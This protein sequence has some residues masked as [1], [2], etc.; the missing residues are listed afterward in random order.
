MTALRIL[1]CVPLVAFV[2]WNRRV[3][4]WLNDDDAFLMQVKLVVLIAGGLASVAAFLWGVGVI[5]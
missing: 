2:V 4:A 1:A 3:F 5:R